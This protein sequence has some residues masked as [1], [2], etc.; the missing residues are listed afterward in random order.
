MKEKL[1]AAPEVGQGL[2]ISCHFQNWGEGEREVSLRTDGL[3]SACLDSSH[4]LD[5]GWAP[6]GPAALS[7][8]HPR[9]SQYLLLSCCSSAHKPSEAPYSQLNLAPP[10]DI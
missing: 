4:G 2:K 7:Y 3:L 10:L 5:P 9:S 1:G 6:L 8:C